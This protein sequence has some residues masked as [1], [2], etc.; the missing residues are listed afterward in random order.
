MLARQAQAEVTAASW[1][2]LAP[3]RPADS[4]IEPEL[5]SLIAGFESQARTNSPVG[6]DAPAPQL[7]R[8]DTRQ[9]QLVSVISPPAPAPQAAPGT[10]LALAGGTPAGTP[11]S[12]GG[13]S[14]P[15]VPQRIAEAWSES[16][17][18][19]IARLQAARRPL[20]SASRDAS[21]EPGASPTAQGSLPSGAG[22]ASSGGATGLAAPAA[23][24]LVVAAA[25]L[26][27]TRLLGRRPT[28][29]PLWRST[30]LCLRLERPG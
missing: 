20:R 28:D 27:A 17:A 1:M 29:P 6:S 2:P 21:A 15:A 16:V 13:W 18:S 26:L 4:A 19:S 3:G 7:A 9:L 22:T 24:L 11:R 12:A 10:G 5:Q 8:A 23:A 25:C 14:A 30:L